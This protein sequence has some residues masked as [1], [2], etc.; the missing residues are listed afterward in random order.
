[1]KVR[2]YDWD[3]KGLKEVAT[4]ESNKGA[5]SALAFSPNGSLLAAGDVSLGHL[6][7]TRPLYVCSSPAAR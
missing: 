4:L 1:M 5:V 3:G 7:D 2:L 6:I